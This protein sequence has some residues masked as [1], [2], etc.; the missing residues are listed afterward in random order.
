M[1]TLVAGSGVALLDDMTTTTSNSPLVIDVD[2]ESEGDGTLTVQT[3]KTVTST[4]SDVTITAWDVDLDGSL[5][6]GTKSIVVHGAQASQ[7]IGIGSSLTRN[8]EILDVELGR[9][10][11]EAGLTMGNVVGGEIQVKGVTDGSS[12]SVGTIILVATKAATAIAFLNTASAF[13]KGI[14]LQAM[15]GVVLSESITSRGQLLSIVSQAHGAQ[16]QFSTAASTFNALVGQADSGILIQVD[17]T[18]DVGILTL[19]ADMDNQHVGGVDDHNK[20][21]MVELLLQTSQP[22]NQKQSFPQGKA[23]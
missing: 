10:T 5:T 9:M 18:T 14:V 6:A 2:F 4:K 22:W 23:P 12:D 11:A 7:T 16:I 3:G 15:G 8:M 21:S 20:S 17:V 13:N 19:D 1:L